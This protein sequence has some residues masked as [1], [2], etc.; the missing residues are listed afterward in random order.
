MKG[1]LEFSEQRFPAK[2]KK[3]L[4]LPSQSAP[5]SCQGGISLCSAHRP[6]RPANQKCARKG[7][8]SSGG[9]ARRANCPVSA[10]AH[11]YGIAR[12]HSWSMCFMVGTLRR[13]RVHNAFVA[14]IAVLKFTAMNRITAAA[15]AAP[16]PWQVYA[17]CRGN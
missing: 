16:P 7:I 14:A 1:F 4:S 3:L 6:G 9:D 12:N 17:R 8:H 5:R 15:A 13:R 2:S 11:P 10:S